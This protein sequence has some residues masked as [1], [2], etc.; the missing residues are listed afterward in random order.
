MPTTRSGLGDAGRD[1]GHRERGGVGR[2]HR[3]RRRRRRASCANSSRF[4]SRSSGRGLDHQVAARQLVERRSRLQPRERPR[5]LGLAPAPALGALGEPVADPL[6]RRLAAP[7]GRGRGGRSR[8]RR[9]RRAG[10]SRRPSSRRRRRRPARRSRQASG[11]APRPPSSRP[12]RRARKKSR[13]P[14]LGG[15]RP[16]AGPTPP[17]LPESGWTTISGA[18]IS[19][20]IR[21]RTGS[22]LRLCDLVGALGRRPGRRPPRPRLEL[23]PARP[24]CAGCGVPLSTISISSLAEVRSGR[25]RCACPGGSSI[26]ARAEPLGAGLRAE[27]W[28]AG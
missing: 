27:P 12:R 7:R 22:S 26:E 5:R 15:V 23:A 11:A 24:A 4:S 18:F 17:N 20:T 1:R 28:R 10:R 14:L 9:G 3:R 6:D 25:G 8:T 16:A 2:E 13:T 21:T 19:L